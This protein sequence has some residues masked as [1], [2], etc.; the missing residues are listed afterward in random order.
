MSGFP[1]EA[2]G[3]GIKEQRDL[4]LDQ[5]RLGTW[6]MEFR[7]TPPL[8]DEAFPNDDSIFQNYVA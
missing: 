3:R 2:A 5:D 1:N 8:S 4:S 7:L 6:G